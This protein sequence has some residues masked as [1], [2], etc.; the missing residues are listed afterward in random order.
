MYGVL[1]RR[2]FSYMQSQTDLNPFFFRFPYLIPPKANLEYFLQI[3][4]RESPVIGGGVSME[5]TVIVSTPKRAPLTGLPASAFQHPL[6]RQ[7]TENLK[8]IK[9]FDWLVKKVLEYGIERIEYVN[10]IGG[11]TGTTFSPTGLNQV[12]IPGGSTLV[13]LT[14]R[15]K[16]T[17]SRC[18]LQQGCSAEVQ[19]RMG[20]INTDQPPFFKSARFTIF[21]GQ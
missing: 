2:V 16:E 17:P 21:R 20:N 13:R 3:F 9:G 6:D 19:M 5:N 8:K 1:I 15:L 14:V 4:H 10:H 12:R 18:P 11:A 7:A